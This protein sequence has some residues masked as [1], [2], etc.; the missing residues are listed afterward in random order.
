MKIYLSIAI[1]LSANVLAGTTQS[2]DIVNSY[3][4]SKKNFNEMKKTYINSDYKDRTNRNRYTTNHN[5]E[6]L[7]TNSD[8][9]DSYNSSRKSFLNKKEL[10]HNTDI[11]KIPLGNLNNEDQTLIN[12]NKLRA[13]GLPTYAEQLE[14]FEKTGSV[15]PALVE[16]NNKALK[17][18]G[19]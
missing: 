17:Q 19:K 12:D 15:H 16:N 8:L 14:Y 18:N 7:T 1:I 2:E 3:N 11:N 9:V 6:S 4:N 10:I 13:Q 5:Q